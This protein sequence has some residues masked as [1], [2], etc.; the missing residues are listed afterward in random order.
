[1]F[2]VLN[3]KPGW[4]FHGSLTVLVPCIFF[5]S[6]HSRRAEAVTDQASKRF[7]LCFIRSSDKRALCDSGFLP[8]PSSFLLLRP[9]FSCVVCCPFSVQMLLKKGKLP[10]IRSKSFTSFADQQG[11]WDRAAS[12]NGPLPESTL[13]RVLVAS[14]SLVNLL[15]TKQNKT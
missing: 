3:W 11:M 5:N 12:L 10:A 1:M 2:G 7:M 14:M 15:K 13:S 4:D 9:S 6:A 8:P